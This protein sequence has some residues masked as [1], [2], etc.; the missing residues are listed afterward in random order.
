MKCTHVRCIKRLSPDRSIQKFAFA[1]DRERM[2]HDRQKH[3]IRIKT[4]YRSHA[5]QNI[6]INIVCAAT[7]SIFAFKKIK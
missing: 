4:F 2:R 6:L 7:C 5:E 1:A 3:S